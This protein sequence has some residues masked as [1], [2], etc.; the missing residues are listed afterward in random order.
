[1]L[2]APLPPIVVLG[3]DQVVD[4]LAKEAVTTN[5]PVGFGAMLTGRRGPSADSRSGGS[6]IV[7][8]DDRGCLFEWLSGDGGRLPPGEQPAAGGGDDG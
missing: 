3:C 2:G 8:F 7:R 1:M 6:Q 5:G 4:L